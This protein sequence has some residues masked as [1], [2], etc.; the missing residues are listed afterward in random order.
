M[1]SKGKQGGKNFVAPMDDEEPALAMDAI[2]Q[3]GAATVDGQTAGLRSTK[4]TDN[5]E[6]QAAVAP[7]NALA[8]FVGFKAA[9]AV[10]PQTDA[11][12]IFDIVYGGKVFLVAFALSHA[13][14]NG[15]MISP[16]NAPLWEPLNALSVG[17]V[18]Q[19]MFGSTIEQVEA[20]LAAM[21]DYDSGTH[22][23]MTCNDIGVIGAVVRRLN[24]VMHGSTSKH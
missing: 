20:G 23:L 19:P 2:V 5:V 22:F 13:T 15:I 3:V 18:L 4:A 8:P 12:L 24:V 17:K 9:L 7:E 10:P 11:P 21:K 14:P 1:R 16:L 6:F